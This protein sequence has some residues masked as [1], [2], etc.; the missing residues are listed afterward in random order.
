METRW[1]LT[2]SNAMEDSQ[3]YVRAKSYFMIEKLTDALLK[4][5]QR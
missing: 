3:L 2:S 5:S 4:V 1:Q